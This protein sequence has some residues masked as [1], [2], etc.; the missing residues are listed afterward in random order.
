M[1]RNGMIGMVIFLLF[2]CHAQPYLD[3]RCCTTNDID[4]ILDV[5]L[6]NMPSNKYY[7]TLI[8][9]YNSLSLESRTNDVS[10]LRRHVFHK[11]LELPVSTNMARAVEHLQV[12]TDWI[13]W[14]AD[15]LWTNGVLGEKDA[16][17]M[18]ASA[19]GVCSWATN[20]LAAAWAVAA[21]RDRANGWIPGATRVLGSPACANLRAWQNEC[22]RREYWN[23]R[24]E[25]YRSKMVASS[26]RGLTILWKDMDENERKRKIKRTVESYGL[27]MPEDD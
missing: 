25:E 9:T 11:V 6:F 21:E 3:R 5:R 10:A 24:A 1:E 14:M 8:K 13:V 12:K 7:R 17:D 16:Y 4:E 23:R 15:E 19:A 20:D 18:L 26:I 2:A 27:E 22:R